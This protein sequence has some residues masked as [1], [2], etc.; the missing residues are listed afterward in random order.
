VKLKKMFSAESLIEMLKQP[1]DMV[2]IV[3]QAMSNV[4]SLVSG[5][6]Q[7]DLGNPNEK[8]RGFTTLKPQLCEFLRL[9]HITSDKR[10]P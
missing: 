9:V 2:D 6:R 1:D 8:K 3:D 5:S 10:P 7:E 4:I